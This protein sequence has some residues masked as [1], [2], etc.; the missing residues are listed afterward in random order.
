[1]RWCVGAPG[2]AVMEERVRS[3]KGEVDQRPAATTVAAVAV[4]AGDG[5]RELR[6]L[7]R[8]HQFRGLPSACTTA[9]IDA[10]RSLRPRFAGQS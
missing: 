1:M 2:V 4:L 7:S 3:L 8:Q 9:V 6:A 10:P 5:A